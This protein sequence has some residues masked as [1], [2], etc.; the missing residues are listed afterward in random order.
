V[1]KILV[2]LAVVAWIVGVAAFVLFLTD[3]TRLHG[4]ALNGHAADG[5][6]YVEEHRRTTEVSQDDWETSRALGVLFVV[7]FPLAAAAQLY[8]AFAVLLPWSVFRA[9]ADERD[10][11]VR[12]VAATGPPVATSKTSARIGLASLGGGMLVTVVHPGGIVL[13][14]RLVGNA[15]VRRTEIRG[16]R[17]EKRFFQRRTVVDHTSSHVR[18]PITLAYRGNDAFVEA[19]K[20]LAPG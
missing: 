15:A 13:R 3:S 19:L 7:S 16:V 12:E 17:D 10:G 11:R 2:P 5:H 18:N 8:L 14:V 6:W 1:K 9:P 20:H 4:S